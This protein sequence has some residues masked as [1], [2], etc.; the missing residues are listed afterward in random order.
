MTAII[1]EMDPTRPAKVN[2]E[3]I[4]EAVVNLGLSIYL[5]QRIGLIGVAIGTL[6][7]SVVLQCF[8]HGWYATRVLAVRWWR[9]AWQVLRGGAP[10]FAAM[11]GVHLLVDPWIEVTSWPLF[12]LKAALV[13]APALPAGLLLSARSDERDAILRRLGLRRS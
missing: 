1:P 2:P 13:A 12:L 4:V 7:P 6:A 10:A 9:Y 11:W 5:V 3:R 8:V